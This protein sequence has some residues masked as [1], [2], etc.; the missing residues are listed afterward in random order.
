MTQSMIQYQPGNQTHDYI[1]INWHSKLIHLPEMAWTFNSDMA[2]PFIFLNY[3]GPPRK[4]I[5]ELDSFNNIEQAIWFEP[6]MTGA[7]IGMWADSSL[8]TSMSGNK[9]IYSFFHEVV[10]LVLKSIP[11]IVS[12]IKDREGVDKFLKMHERLG[13]VVSGKIPHVFD[14]ADAYVLYLTQKNL[15]QAM[16]RR[17]KRHGRR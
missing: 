8:R 1:L 16:D 7:Y 6:I 14:S 12:T 9:R 17:R 11:T 5:V 15:V 13:F 10:E 4:L 2:S 3:F